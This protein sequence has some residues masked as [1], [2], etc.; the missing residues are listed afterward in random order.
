L[1]APGNIACRR[2]LRYSG[3][4]RND[5]GTFYEKISLTNAKDDVRLDCGLLD[6]VR[7]LTLEAMPDTGAR[8]TSPK[9]RGLI[10]NEAIRQ[11]LGLSI[12]GAVESSMADGS[13]TLHNL[14]EA[15]EI[16]WKDRLTIQQAV[17]MPDANGVLLGALPLEGLDLYVD[18][19]NQRLAGVHGDKPVY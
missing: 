1:D 15:V 12:V 8:T 10:I 9:G 4:K 18:P 13:T 2:L 14:T 5:R 3:Y 16:R 11:R 6:E 17:V 19:V 7:T